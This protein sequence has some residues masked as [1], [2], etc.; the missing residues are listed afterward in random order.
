MR[1]FPTAEGSP[2]ISGYHMRIFRPECNPTFQSVHCIAYLERAI[3][4]VLPYLNT[5]QNISG[6]ALQII[7]D[8]IVIG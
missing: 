6:A 4:V 3:R 5:V 2:F 1:L 7:Q 8:E